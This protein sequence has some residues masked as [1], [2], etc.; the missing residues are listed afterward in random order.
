MSEHEDFPTRWMGVKEVSEYLGVKPA[1][2]YAYVSER[3]IP[4]HKVPG[5][6]LLKFKASE[7]DEWMETGRVE[8][9]EEYLARIK[10]RSH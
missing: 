5:S 3:R 4:F 9:K 7:I 1:T 10:E 8:T 2:I 6:Q